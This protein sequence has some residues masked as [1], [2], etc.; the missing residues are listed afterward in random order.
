M[1]KKIKNVLEWI[2]VIATIIGIVLGIVV[3]LRT[4]GAI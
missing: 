1:K 3:I 4:L 2:L